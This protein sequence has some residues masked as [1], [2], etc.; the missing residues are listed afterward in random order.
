M[1]KVLKKS[2]AVALSGLF[3]LNT[4][5]CPIMCNV[6]A[7]NTPPSSPRKVTDVNNEFQGDDGK[8]YI[9]GESIDRG[10]QSEVFKCIR[11][12]DGKECIVKIPINELP[13]SIG[14]YGQEYRD[15]VLKILKESLIL[16]NSEFPQVF[17]NRVVTTSFAPP[18]T[19]VKKLTRSLFQNSLRTKKPIIL[20]FDEDTSDD[21]ISPLDDSLLSDDE[22][23]LFVSPVKKLKNENPTTSPTQAAKSDVKVAPQHIEK[24]VVRSAF[25]DVKPDV[26]GTHLSVMEPSVVNMLRATQITGTVPI[27]SYRPHIEDNMSTTLK[28]VIG[29]PLLMRNISMWAEEILDVLIQLNN[30]GLCHQD[31]KPDNIFIEYGHA[32]VGD[33]GLVCSFNQSASLSIGTPAYMAPEVWSRSTRDPQLCDRSDVFSL[34]MTILEMLTDFRATDIDCSNVCSTNP[35]FA[36]RDRNTAIVNNIDKY[37]LRGSGDP[38]PDNWKSFLRF[39]LAPNPK[40]RPT[41]KQAKILLRELVC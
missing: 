2:S 40:N 3:L 31:I 10:N 16:K 20:D 21:D 6:T 37:R 28:S 35:Y 25:P 7:V 33:L 4:H 11:K 15:Q 38:I 1:K 34:G 41:A 27:R 13:I 36:Y 39:C 12:E 29:S 26:C 18:P 5:F 8:W 22:A 19:P 23:D 9:L 30:L 14:D 17:S 24:C 32:L